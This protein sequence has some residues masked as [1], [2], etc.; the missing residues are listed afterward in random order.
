MAPDRAMARNLTI[1]TYLV[2][3]VGVHLAHVALVSRSR[4]HEGA[5]PDVLLVHP[6][7]VPVGC[8]GRQRVSARVVQESRQ[9]Y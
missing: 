8:G 1:D 9:E 2:G 7:R 5:D 4:H 3:M 6:G